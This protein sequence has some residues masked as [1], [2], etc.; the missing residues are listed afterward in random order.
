MTKPILTSALRSAAALAVLYSAAAIAA[1]GDM[2]PTPGGQAA[3]PRMRD[4]APLPGERIEADLAY[5]KTALKLT[6]SQ[7]P[8]WEPV[9]N[10][11]RA[12]AKRHDAEAAEHRAAMEKAGGAPPEGDLIAHLE[13]RQHRLAAEAD[14]LAKLETAVKPLY[15]LLT[16]EQKKAAD[17][18]LPPPPS[19]REMA[20]AMPHSDMMPPP[21]AGMMPP[22]ARAF[23]R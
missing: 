20:L 5:L 9:A 18:L 12:Q 2:P 8:A 22:G 13:D 6:E 15:A 3:V 1:P 14:D 23:A 21:G 10:V 16:P 17:E 7:L 11:L 4:V 19:R